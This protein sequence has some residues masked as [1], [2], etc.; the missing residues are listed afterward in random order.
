MAVNYR[1]WITAAAACGLL[2]VATLVF[3][4]SANGP[5]VHS[6]TARTTTPAK[7]QPASRNVVPPAATDSTG[8]G[9]ADSATAG[10]PAQPAA[11][12]TTIIHGAITAPVARLSIEGHPLNLVDND[13]LLTFTS[14]RY[15]QI[16]GYISPDA[17]K[18]LRIHIDQYTNI[19]LSP[20]MA[21][22]IKDLYGTRN[23]GKPTRK[24]RKTKERLEKWQATDQKRFDS[25]RLSNPLDPF[26]LA[27]FLFR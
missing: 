6:S 20:V 9:P 11:P 22:F 7:T 24:A 17:D 25:S 14:Y 16:A 26:D 18:D 13:L 19:T 3:Y 23:N 8:N 27:D 4:R 12:A 5:S 10:A 1:R 21:G 15:P 2:A